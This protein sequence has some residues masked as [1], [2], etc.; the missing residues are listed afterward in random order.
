M[1]EQKK[2]LV[3]LLVTE[4]RKHKTPWAKIKTTYEVRK[5]GELGAQKENS[6]KRFSPDSSFSPPP[7]L[8][9]L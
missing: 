5:F 2:K 3:C 9:L 1:R 7:P 8:F 4:T 6:D